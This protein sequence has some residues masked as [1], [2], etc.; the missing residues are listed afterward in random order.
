MIVSFTFCVLVCHVW[1]SHFISESE[2]IRKKIFWKR[3]ISST[4][5]IRLNYMKYRL[6]ETAVGN[7][8]GKGDKEEGPLR[9]DTYQYFSHSAIRQEAL[10]LITCAYLFSS[11]F[12]VCWMSESLIS[13]SR[14]E[15]LVSAHC[16]PWSHSNLVK[17]IR[18]LQCNRKMMI[19]HR[20]FR[21]WGIS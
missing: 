13:W 7:R 17:Q 6:E 18:M 21:C 4:W 14:S 11:F 20:L 15:P 19:K 2:S 3:D 10:N 8:R 9:D 1:L 5:T 16:H 12:R